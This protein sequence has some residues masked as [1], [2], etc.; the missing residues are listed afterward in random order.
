MKLKAQ[1]LAC[2]DSIK[3]VRDKQKVSGYIQSDLRD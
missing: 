3:Y 1:E 2:I